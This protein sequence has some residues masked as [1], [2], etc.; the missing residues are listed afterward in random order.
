M[1]TP[2]I[3]HSSHPWLPLGPAV[4][5]SMETSL[6]LF[7]GLPLV[8]PGFS[9]LLSGWWD[10]ALQPEAPPHTHTHTH[11]PSGSLCPCCLP[12]RPGS[13]AQTQARLPAWDCFLNRYLDCVSCHLPTEKGVRSQPLP[14]VPLCPAWLSGSPRPGLP[15]HAP[16]GPEECFSA[17]SGLVSL[18]DCCS[19]TCV[20]LWHL[21]CSAL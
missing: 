13:R 12:G 3:G 1:S 7:Q 20:T 21:A 15:S 9:H 19:L 10:R 5:V 17:P 11:T 4:A 16:S 8:R 6:C 18:L 14:Y 2:G